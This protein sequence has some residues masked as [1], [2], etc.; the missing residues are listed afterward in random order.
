MEGER[1]RERERQR[2]REEE[3]EEE[4]GRLDPF[5]SPSRSWVDL[6]LAGPLAYAAVDYTD[7]T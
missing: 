6:S 7:P 1:E 2:Q 5:F 3:E 4:K